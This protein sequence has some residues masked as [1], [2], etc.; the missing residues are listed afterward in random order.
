MK[1]YL[2]H[3]NLW[4]AIS[5][6]ADKTSDKISVEERSRRDE[7]ALSKINLMVNQCCFSYLMKCETAKQAWDALENAGLRDSI[8]VWDFFVVYVP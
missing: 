6:Y 5:G 7:K 4:I 1:N 3:D 8:D 2:Q